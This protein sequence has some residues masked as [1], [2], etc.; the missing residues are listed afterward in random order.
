MV[1]DIG[2]AIVRAYVLRDER[3]RV[4]PVIVPPPLNS[5]SCEAY[6]CTERKDRKGEGGQVKAEAISALLRRLYVL[7]LYSFAGSGLL[8]LLLGH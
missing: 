1:E 5:S 6:A 8:A 2:V 7:R 3:A 4:T